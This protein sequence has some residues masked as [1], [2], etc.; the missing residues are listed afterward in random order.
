MERGIIG[1]MFY[2]C[3]KILCRGGARLHFD[4]I[5]NGNGFIFGPISVFQAGIGKGRHEGIYLEGRHA[6]DCFV[7]RWE[8]HTEVLAEILRQDV[9]DGD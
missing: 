7:E 8:N 5:R 9:A 3:E 4:L 1:A 6:L 2:A